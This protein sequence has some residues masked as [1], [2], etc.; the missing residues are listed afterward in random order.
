[1]TASTPRIS[2]EDC[3]NIT[4][5]GVKT[6]YE[7][8]LMKTECEKHRVGYKTRKENKQKHRVGY[9]TRKENKQKHKR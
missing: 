6:L 4:H 1:M 3:L 5:V 2:A 7:I 8:S 9:K